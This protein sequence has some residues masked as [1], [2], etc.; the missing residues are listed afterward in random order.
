MENNDIT[1]ERHSI[2]DEQ[3]VA[4]QRRIFT[5][6]ETFLPRDGTG[7]FIRPG[8]FA[9]SKESTDAL[10]LTLVTDKSGVGECS[11]CLDGIGIGGQICAMP[12]NHGFH[13]GCI[14]K[15]LGIR[16]SCPVCRFRVPVVARR[17]EEKE[18]RRDDEDR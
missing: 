10:P 1:E 12:C 18:N 11:I 2:S 13:S 3:Y 17:Q 14:R 9:A 6:L 7:N 8:R 16:R 4:W 5:I 15:W